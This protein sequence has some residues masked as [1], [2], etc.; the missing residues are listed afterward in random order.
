MSRWE[1]NA[2]G[3]LEDAALQLYSERGFDRTTVTEIAQRAGLTERTFF[4][5][6]ADKREVLF[7]GDG[8]LEELVTRA[9]AEAGESVPPIDAVADGLRAFAELIRG[10]REHDRTRRQIIAANPSLQ[11][12]ELI[13]MARLAAATSDALRRRGVG[14]PAA[15][16]TAEAAIAVFKVAFERWLTDGEDREL[17]TVIDECLDELKAVGRR[18]RR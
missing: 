7:R 2:R 10:R 1:P 8:A 5:Y 13:K 18:G 15:S 6:F 16:L 12:R 14:E 11:E 9:V 3:R 4:R 17:S